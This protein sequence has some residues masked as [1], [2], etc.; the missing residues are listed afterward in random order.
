MK[1]HF[2]DKRRYLRDT[3]DLKESTENRASLEVGVSFSGLALR[4]CCGSCSCSF[5]LVEKEE[6]GL[7]SIGK[8]E[9]TPQVKGNGG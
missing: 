6:V 4:P 2:K 5:L 7:Q 3:L 9:I 1:N 8:K